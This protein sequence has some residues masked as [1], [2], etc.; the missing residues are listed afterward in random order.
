MFRLT[1]V[2]KLI[3]I[4]GYRREIATLFVL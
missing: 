2:S 4:E 3:M 1:C